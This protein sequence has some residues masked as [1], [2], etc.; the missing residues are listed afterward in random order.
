M[1]NQEGRINKTL[2]NEQW[3][4]LKQ[5]YE[6]LVKKGILREVLVIEGAPGCEDMVFAANQSFPWVTPAGQYM[7]VMSKMYHES[8]R[9]EVPFFESYY[10]NLGYEILYLKHTSFFE[11]MGDTIVH[12]GKR[13]L[14][15]GYGHRSTLNAYG[16]LSQLLQ[17]PVITLELPDNRFYHLD[18]CFVPLDHETVMLC[19]EAFTEKGLESLRKIFKNIIEI[20]VEEAE[21]NFSLNAHVLSG[22]HSETKTAIIQKGS[23]LTISAIKKH[24]FDVVEVD[25]SEFMKSGGSVFCMKMMIY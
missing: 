4:A 20:P 9:R 22:K 11:G 17:V 13:L 2:A 3:L 6:L 19:K 18:T 21:N 10:Q 16:E 24:G 15:G 12:P 1:K 8:R 14:Y 25:T 5:T 7:V 23:P